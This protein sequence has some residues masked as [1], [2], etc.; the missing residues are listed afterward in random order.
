MS[1]YSSFE[2]GSVDR[3]PNRF[4][5]NPV[6]HKNNNDKAASTNAAA[7]A[8]GGGGAATTDDVPHEIY[9]R[10]TGIDGEPIEDDQFN[11]DASQ[12]LKAQQQHRT[13]RQSIKSSFRD[14]DK[15]SRFK[16]LQTTRFQVEPQNE[17]DSDDSNEDREL[18]ENEYDTK[19]GKSFRHFTREALPRLDNYRNIMSIQAA[20]RPTLDELHNATLT[21]KNTHSLNRNQ[22]PEAGG[23]AMNGMLKFGWI[24]GVLVRCLLN[25]W[26]VMLFLR[27]SWVVGQA[28]IMEGF[29]L[30]LTTTIV[31]SITALSMSAISTNGVIKG[32]GTYYMI[33]RSLGPEFGGSIGL[34]FSLAN[35]VA[36]AMYVV[37]FCESMLDLLNSMGLSII[38]GSIQ[39]VRIIGSITI[40]ILLV[41]VVVGM[42]WEA[43]AQIGL[44][45]ILLIAIADFVIGSIIGP[46]SDEERAQGFL[47]YNMTLLKDN[48]F[49]DY[50]MEKGVRH[51]FFSVF[52]IFFPAATGILAGANISGDLKDPQKSIPKGTLLAILITTITYLIMVVIAGATVARDA[53]G[54]VAD[55]VNG[56]FAFLNCTGIVCEYGLQNSFQVI[57]LVSGF[58]P[59]IYAGC[60]AATLSSA[61]ASLVSAPKV[62][63]ALCKDE[64]YPKIVWFA[65]GFGKNNEP[66]RG[67]VLTFI[68][69]VAFILIGE[70][71]LIAPLI[72]NFFLAAYM[73]IN[74]STFH[75]SL[76][77]PVGWRPTFKYYN[78]WLSLLGSIL[79]VA[80]MFLISW[81]T[82]LITF[83]V[84]LALYLI[85]AYRK[86][87]V[88]WG[89]TT[90]A[91]TYKNALLSVQQLN[92]VEEHVKNYRPQILVLSGLPNTR[93]VL[94]DFAYMLTKNL[95]LMVCG[96]VL[97]GSSSQRYRNYLQERA[98]T[99][100]RR[101]RV[102]G[103]YSLVDGEDFESGS[104]ALMQAAGIGKLKPNILLMGYKADWQ[105]C[106]HKDLNQYFNI[107]HKALDMYLSVAI[108]RVPEGLDCSQILGDESSAQ[109]NIFDVPRTLQPNESSADLNAVDRSAQ[110]GL[111]GSMD[112]L[113]RNVSQDAAE[114][115]NTE[116]NIKLTKAS[117]TSDLSFMT[118]TQTKEVSGLPD[119]ADPKS[120]QLL[121]NSLRKSKNKHDDP[122][123][124][125]KGPGGVEL[126]KDVLNQLTQFTRKRSHAVIDV[127]WLYDDGGLT[128][129]LP[130]II[131]T[132]RTWQSCKLR[133]YAL[134]NKKAE[135]E[136]EQRSMAS[137]LSKFR[138]DYS[139]LQLIPDITKKPQET[140]TQFFNELIKDFVVN[141]KETSTTANTTQLQEDEVLISEDDL[142][143]VQDK[144]NRYLRLRE[145]LREQSTKS[146]LVVMTL[147]MPRKNIVTAPLYMAWLESLSRDMPPFLFVRGNQTSVLTFYS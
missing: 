116:S 34:I 9:R 104:R 48:F 16:D 56:S 33:S 112:S 109:R 136:F 57:E 90:Q 142:M 44:L 72:S 133:V 95:S 86:P 92:N 117:S 74:F 8:G 103:F 100:F 37:G 94:V 88:N 51:D 131:S 89:S 59:L 31:T 14:K 124:L 107:M 2:M 62:F 24:K 63:Q 83:S 32:G 121:T 73:L 79:C 55:M 85:V 140:S 12:M 46:K 28:G 115:T 4:Q 67:Y 99:W 106:E 10:L 101:H 76:A 3:P 30:I 61:L 43:K 114:I 137:L 113:S 22:D 41:I 23:G 87:D 120:P 141:E 7:T 111:S 135:L 81:A 130:Y 82:A 144:T 118:G 36:C 15:P 66:V 42:E 129:L 127:W 21:G 19:Y 18:L 68:I 39:D 25:I 50:R 64:L 47:G 110:N 17:E 134:A 78:M 35:A 97:R 108:L 26:G 5:V 119:P 146:D 13:Q 1:D 40:L 6:N 143:A 60:F 98:T 20:Y 138:I 53:T 54:D 96:H 27:L 123:A 128:L 75:A 102:K 132:R 65:K 77:K 45:I 69:A 139:D 11:E 122:A 84:V 71:N 80:V 105:T 38:D 147:P 125:Y 145:Y 70:L 29:I 49:A 58:G 93:P 126:S 52:A 91:Q